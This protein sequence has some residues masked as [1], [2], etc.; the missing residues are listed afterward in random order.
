MSDNSILAIA[1]TGIQT[2]LAGMKKN[3]ATIA[4]KEA[5]ENPSLH[6]NEIVDMKMNQ[7]QVLASGKVIETVDEI[8]GSMLDEKT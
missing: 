3:A 7:Y 1:Q 2:G 4:S 5:A 6:L 8:L